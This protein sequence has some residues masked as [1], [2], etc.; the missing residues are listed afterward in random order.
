MDQH[1]DGSGWD[2]LAHVEPEQQQQQH[3]DQQHEQLEQELLEHIDRQQTLEAQ[4]LHEQEQQHHEQQVEEPGAGQQPQDVSEQYHEA[5]PGKP[6]TTKRAR[7]AGEARRKVDPRFICPIEGC[8]ATFTRCVWTC[9]HAA[10]ARGRALTPV[11]S[12]AA[13]RTTSPATCARTAVRPFVPAA[14]PGCET[15]QR[16]RTLPRPDSLS[17]AQ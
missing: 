12:P 1:Y 14:S 15:D 3:A 8:G 13:G 11:V 16:Y 17:G 9:S 5:V 10:A 4:E 6:Q 7:E 2:Q